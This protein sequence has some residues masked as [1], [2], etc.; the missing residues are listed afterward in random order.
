MKRLQFLMIFAMASLGLFAQTQTFHQMQSMSRS[1]LIDLAKLEI[2]TELRDQLDAFDSV[3]VGRN[4]QAVLVY[5]SITNRFVPLNSQYVYG[6]TVRYEGNKEEP[7]VHYE[8]YA[9]PKNYSRPGMKPFRYYDETKALLAHV[10]EVLEREA[11]MYFENGKL[12]DGEIM[13]LYEGDSYVQVD[14][15]TDDW[16]YHGKVSKTSDLISDESYLTNEK[17]DLIKDDTDE[18]FEEVFE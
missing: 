14:I 9:N 15:F 12:P 5:F 10:I 1:E 11:D 18:V 4:D 13:Y 2:T 7:F 6:I 17:I 8:K 3:F 16:E